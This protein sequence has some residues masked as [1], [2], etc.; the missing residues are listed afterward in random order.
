ME[1]VNPSEQKSLII[2]LTQGREMANELK[3]QLDPATSP[4]TCEALVEK[5]LSIYDR[6]LSMLTWRA[7]V[8]ESPQSH[9]PAAAPAATSPITDGSN[10]FSKDQLSHKDVCKKR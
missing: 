4:E 10:G 6:A 3:K 2:E 9:S 8:G 5:M 7:V 1:K